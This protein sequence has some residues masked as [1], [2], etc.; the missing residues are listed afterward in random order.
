MHLFIIDKQEYRKSLKVCNVLSNCAQHKISISSIRRFKMEGT[1][2][3]YN[4]KKGYGFIAG[5][6]DKEYFVHFTGLTQ[7][8]KLYTDDV[9]EFEAAETEKGLQ[10]QKV[11]KKEGS[12]S[13]P[14]ENLAE[15]NK[16][17]EVADETSGKDSEEEAKEDSEVKTEEDSE[18]SE[19]KPEVSEESPEDEPEEAKEKQDLDEVPSFE[20]VKKEVQEEA[21]ANKAEESEEPKEEAEKKPEASEEDSKTSEK[22]A[23]TQ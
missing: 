8:T 10:A 7:G 16:P 4:V 12:A 22:E 9:V 19:E 17:V 20:E 11:S 1:V 5:S 14:K 6:D 15:D 13:T 2:K 21:D 23:E 3:W 18:K